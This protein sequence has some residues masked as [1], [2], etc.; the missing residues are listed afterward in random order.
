[1]IFSTDCAHRSVT[2]FS[3]GLGLLYEPVLKG[4]HGARAAAGTFS[5]GLRHEP[6]LKVRYNFW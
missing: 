6:V 5:T 1:M 3:T 2:I 4:F